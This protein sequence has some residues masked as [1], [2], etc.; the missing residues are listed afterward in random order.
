MT[1]ARYPAAT[2][3]AKQAN[4]RATASMTADNFVLN[5]LM[6]VQDVQEDIMLKAA[7]IRLDARDSARAAAMV[8]AVDLREEHALKTAELTGRSAATDDAI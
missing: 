7:W 2:D 8:S 6:I 5:S 4:I 3:A 1:A